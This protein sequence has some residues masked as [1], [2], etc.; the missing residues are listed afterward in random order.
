MSGTAVVIALG[1]VVLS[2][3]VRGAYSTF[4]CLVDDGQRRS[5]V[6]VRGAYLTFLYAAAHG[7]V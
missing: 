3:M 6:M 7:L 2:V 5:L 1:R 4:R